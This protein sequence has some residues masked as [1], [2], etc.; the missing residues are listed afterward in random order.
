M[1][2]GSRVRL[3]LEA[4]PPHPEAELLRMQK[5]RCAGCRQELPAASKGLASWKTNA[6]VR[7]EPLNPQKPQHSKP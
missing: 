6:K 4:P 7:P 1:G 5:G 3:I 2:Y